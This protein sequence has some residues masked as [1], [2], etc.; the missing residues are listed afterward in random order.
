[1][2]THGYVGLGMMGGAMCARLAEAGL[3][4]LLVHDLAPH[5][6]ERVVARGATAA[7]STVAL[8]EQADIISTCV[9]AAEHV[10][11]VV[12]DLATVRKSGQ[13][14]I[15]H[16]TVHPETVRAANERVADWGGLVFDA[17]VAG[18]SDAAKE[19]ELAVFAG[20]LADAPAEVR[21]LLDVYGSKIFD[22]GPV[23]AGAAL[24][25]AVNIMTY[26]QFSAAAIAH[27]GVVGAGGD[28]AALLD[29]WRH[30]GMLG[31]LTE[32]YSAMLGISV[33]D[34]TGEFRTMLETQAG[35]AD[36]DLELAS[37]LGA[38]P[39]G[40]AAVVN[41]IRNLMPAVYRTTRWEDS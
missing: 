15:I 28:P 34:V 40:A 31:A 17:C 23:G 19:G 35:V 18:G 11:A 8:A 6:V 27:E 4:P 30:V 21:A 26:A 39:D 29:A 1:M 14:L 20:G 41:A 32:S 38:P 12:D 13:V 25:I 33:D 36:K 24:K 2:T 37:T 5:R 9:P 16:S 22:A 3:G 10:A 7:G